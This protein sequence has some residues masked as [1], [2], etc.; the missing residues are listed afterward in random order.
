MKLRKLAVSAF[1]SLV[2]LGGTVSA[3]YIRT[4]M[5]QYVYA[6]PCSQLKGISGLLQRSQFFSNGTCVSTQAGCNVGT[7]CG[8]SNPPSGDP[9]TGYCYQLNNHRWPPP[10][11]CL[12]GLNPPSQ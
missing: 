1:F 2:V 8:I 7:V 3:A 6:A 12:G 5:T 9:V 10:C 11:V 4:T